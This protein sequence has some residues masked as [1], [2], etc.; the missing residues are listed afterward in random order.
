[1]SVA[2]KTSNKKKRPKHL[3][4]MML[5]HYFYMKFHSSENYGL[6]FDIWMRHD[7]YVSYENDMDI[8]ENE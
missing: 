3:K 4:L 1:M 5:R 2:F 6:K 8:S 7:I